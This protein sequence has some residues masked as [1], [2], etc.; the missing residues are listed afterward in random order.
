ME[1]SFALAE[2]VRGRGWGVEAVRHACDWAAGAFELSDLVAVTAA[3]NAASRRTLAR[4][5]F[6]HEAD[7]SMRFQGEVALVSRYRWRR[8]PP[9]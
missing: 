7:A 4:V 3:D 8:E 1:V 9:R 6:A 5:G 2:S